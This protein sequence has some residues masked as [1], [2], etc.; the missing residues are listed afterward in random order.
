MMDS[1]ACTRTKSCPCPL[2]SKSRVHVADA[3]L[4]GPK[5]SR[6]NRIWPVHHADRGECYVGGIQAAQDEETLRQKGITHVV[7]CMQRPSLNTIKD[8]KYLNFDIENWHYAL[9]KPIKMNDSAEDS[10]A[11]AAAVL[12]LFQPVFDFVDGAIASGTGCLIHCFAGAHRAGT[13]GVAFLMHTERLSAEAALAL[14][15]RMRP[16]IAPKD[17][18]DLWHLLLLLEAGLKLRTDGGASTKG[19]PVDVP[20]GPPGRQEPAGVL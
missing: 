10:A 2:C 12:A 5:Y 8:V 9:P 19:D 15:E 7:N 14:A 18:A 20:P 1:P 13:T 16:V 17:Y 4:R 3:F 6:L 11:N